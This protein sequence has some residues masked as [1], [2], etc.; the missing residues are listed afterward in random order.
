MTV[1]AAAAAVALAIATVGTARA[2][3]IARGATTM[4]T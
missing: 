2:A 4:A 3:T 1:P